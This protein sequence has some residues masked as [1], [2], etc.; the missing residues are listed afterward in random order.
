MSLAALQPH[1]ETLGWS[2]LTVLFIIVGSYLIA[3]LASWIAGR[4]GQ[5]GSEQRKIFWGFLFASPWIIGFVIFVVGPALTSLYYSFTDYK[6]GDPINWVGLNNYATLLTGKG[7]AGKQFAQAMYNSFYYAIIGVP[8]Q[9]IAA[10]LMAMLLNQDLKGIRIFR[11]IFYIPVI[12]AGGPAV[13]LAWRYMLASNGGFIN[14]I[15]HAI[16]SHVFFVD[17]IYRGFIYA[18]EGFNGFY[19]GVVKGDPIGPLKYTLP[20][21]LGAMTLL[22]LAWGAWS[23]SKRNLALNVA[24]IVGVITGALLFAR[25][26][27]TDPF[28]PAMIFGGGLIVLPGAM[29]AAWRGG[30]KRARVWQIGTLLIA[31]VTI[32]ALLLTSDDATRAVYIPLIVI[33]AAPMVVSL[34]GAWNRRKYMLLGALAVV[35]LVLVAA[36]M[37]PQMVGDN[38]W[39][40]LTQVATLQTSVPVTTDTKVLNAYGDVTPSSLWLY[41]LV[42]AVVAG[43]AWANNRNPRAQ[44]IVILVGLAVFALIAVG[45][46]LDGA[47]YF[48]AFDAVAQAT[49]KPNYHFALFNKVVGVFPDSNRAPLWLTS[50]LWT[51]PSLILITMWSSGAGMLIFLAALK[52]VPKAFYEAAEVDGASRWQRFYK[53]TLPLISP[54]LFYNIVIGV[55]A[56]LQTF[57]SVYIISD[58]NTQ[59]SLSSAAYFLFVRTFRQLAIGQG[60]AV[61]WILAAIIILL[62]ALQFRYSN[63]VHYEN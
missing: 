39:Q 40:T 38:R 18:V 9:V 42:V 48:Q 31:I 24:E 51:K 46:I 22:A 6:L 34:F 5:P 3:R 12:L 20:A 30:A 52:G 57:E 10:L 43:L 8:L 54:A 37:V 61:S 53:I 58:Q 4:A 56:A 45:S 28:E 16:A 35:L 36:R 47:R 60:A 13:L 21:L 49:S 26:M 19:V 23:Q 41:L 33:A 25:G 32:A 15:S 27:I 7:T 44:R 14:E 17:W 62:T 2:A 59:D 63:W 11:L 55:I 29:L 50:E 1:L